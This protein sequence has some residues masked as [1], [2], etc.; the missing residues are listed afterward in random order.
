MSRKI[1][2]ELLFSLYLLL[3]KKKIEYDISIYPS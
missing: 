1:G 2:N 3:G